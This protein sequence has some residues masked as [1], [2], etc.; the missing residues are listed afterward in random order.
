MIFERKL[1]LWVIIHIIVLNLWK[2]TKNN[3]FFEPVEDTV[4]EIKRV[5]IE[6]LG[7]GACDTNDVEDMLDG[8]AEMKW[9]DHEE[10]MRKLAKIF[11]NIYFTLIG[12]GEDRRDYWI[13]QFHGNEYYESYAEI[14]EPERKW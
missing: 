13:K 7:G 1:I 2:E 10:D 14:I 5:L 8:M 12:E 3:G 11:P 9:Y 4:K 6:I